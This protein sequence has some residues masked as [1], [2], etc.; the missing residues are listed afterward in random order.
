M[1]N[2]TSHSK[3]LSLAIDLL[4]RRSNTPEDAGCQEL[5][6]SRLEPLG[7]KIE[8]MRFGNVDNLYARRGNAGPLLV[9]AGH[10]D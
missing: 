1:T 6:I 4:T 2:S 3:T 5:M 9:F 8:R 7:F 10:T